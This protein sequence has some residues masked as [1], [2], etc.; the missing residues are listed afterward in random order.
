M[1]ISFKHGMQ[2]EN[3]MN[4]IQ[5]PTNKPAIGHITN[6][7]IKTQIMDQKIFA[8]FTNLKCTIKFLHHENFNLFFLK[9]FIKPFK[10]SCLSDYFNDFFMI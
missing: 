3:G 7:N 5:N 1:F 9:K 6:N 2:A 10:D 8:I 4:K